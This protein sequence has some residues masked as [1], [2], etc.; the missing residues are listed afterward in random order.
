MNFVS[1]SVR[2]TFPSALYARGDPYETSDAVLGV[3]D[4]LVVDYTEVDQ[5]TARNYGVKEGT[6]LM[7]YDFVLVSDGEAS[8]LRDEKSRKALEALGRKV[9]LI[10]GLPVPDID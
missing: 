1:S 7:I 3:K 10:D 4:S 9:K 8:E 5:G 2:L 6:L